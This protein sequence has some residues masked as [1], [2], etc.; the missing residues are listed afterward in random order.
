MLGL[1]RDAARAEAQ[2]LVNLALTLADQAETYA[3]QEAATTRPTLTCLS[4]FLKREAVQNETAL[5]ELITREQGGNLQTL[6]V[7]Q[8]R[9]LASAQRMITENVQRILK[10]SPFQATADQT[11]TLTQK[12]C[13]AQTA[14]EARTVVNEFRTASPTRAGARATVA[15][16]AGIDA[17]EQTAAALGEYTNQVTAASATAPAPANQPTVME[18]AEKI[19]GAKLDAC[20]IKGSDVV[21]TPTLTLAPNAEGWIEGVLLNKYPAKGVIKF[22]VTFPFALETEQPSD[23]NGYFS[24]DAELTPSPKTATWTASGSLAI[25]RE[26]YYGAD[27][28]LVDADH[29]YDGAKT[30]QF[31]GTART[32]LAYALGDR[33]TGTIELQFKNSALGRKDE[34]LAVKVNRSTSRC[35]DSPARA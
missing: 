13:A 11:Q 30:R 27:G 23:P 35:S 5:V 26:P 19:F 31:K 12:A 17:L 22:K 6:T 3:A 4:T 33:A 2:R 34:D 20:E 14:G 24:L 9:M 25:V 8:R 15:I 10:Q 1:D 28:V 29:L 16:A 32:A 21:C 18:R 7:E